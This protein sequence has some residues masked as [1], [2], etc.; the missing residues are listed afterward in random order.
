MDYNAC[1]KE[2]FE[3]KSY[4]KT[5][6]IARSRLYFKVQNFITPTIKLNFKSHKK[7]QS[8]KFICSDCME[9][10]TSLSQSTSSEPGQIQ[11]EISSVKYKGYPDDQNHLML[12]CRANEDLREG[13]NVMENENDCVTF[14]SNLFKEELTNSAELGISYVKFCFGS[15]HGSFR[16]QSVDDE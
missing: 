11:V 8:E 6:N 14:F 15:N 12:F 10:E 16:S 7:F 4:F 9:S 1:E 5:M 3:V 2:K 13:L